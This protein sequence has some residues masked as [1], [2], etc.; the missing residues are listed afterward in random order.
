[1]IWTVRL[2]KSA[3]KFLQ[4]CPADVRRR[5]I[6]RIEELEKGPFPRGCLRLRGRPDV[7]RLRLGHYRIVYRILWQETTVLVFRIEPRA[8]AYQ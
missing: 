8:R 6:H 7:W 4:N 1:M 3:F 5:A 2:S